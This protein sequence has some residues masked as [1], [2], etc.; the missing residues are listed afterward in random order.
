MDAAEWL[1]V[2]DVVGSG[3]CMG[4]VVAV[5]WQLVEFFG[6]VCGRS[7]WGEVYFVGGLGP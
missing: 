7:D 3:W 4:V 5:D 6:G 2:G 1:C